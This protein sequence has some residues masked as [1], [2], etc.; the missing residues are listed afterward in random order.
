MPFCMSCCG[1]VYCFVFSVY[2]VCWRGG[3]VIFWGCFLLGLLILGRDIFW[4]VGF[5]CDAVF[6]GVMV[7]WFGD[8]FNFWGVGFCSVSVPFSVLLDAVGCCFYVGALV[9]LV[10][11]FLWNFWA[12]VEFCQ[13]VPSPICK[14]LN[15]GVGLFIVQLETSA[16]LIFYFSKALEWM[17]LLNYCNFIF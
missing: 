16:P 7:F 5:L 4:L 10:V 1:V 14:F 11:W 12:F 13:F 8:G 9:G 17:W 15:F 6:C 3:V 2:S